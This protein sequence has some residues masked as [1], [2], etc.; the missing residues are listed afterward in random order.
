MGGQL[1]LAAAAA[2]GLA[3]GGYGDGVQSFTVD[4]GHHHQVIGAAKGRFGTRS[5]GK[6]SARRR[7][8]LFL[9]FAVS[10]TD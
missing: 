5:F 1:R 2:R 4:H 8:L 9:E 7:S 6:E 3:V 10:N